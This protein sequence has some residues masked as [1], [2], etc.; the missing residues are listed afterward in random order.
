ME[1]LSENFYARDTVSVANDLL[2]KVLVHESPQGTTSGIIVETEAYLENDPA[3]HAYRGMT[4]RNA[5]MFGPPGKAYVYLIYGIH[6]CFNAVTR[7][8]GKGE[9][10]LV[11]SLCPLE[12][13]EL[14]R[15]RRGGKCRETRLSCGPGNLCKS[16]GINAG[17]DKI[18]LEDSPLHVLSDNINVALEDIGV[19]KRVG[20]NKGDNIFLRFYLKGYEKFVSGR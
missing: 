1:V 2:G 5:T 4:K 11:R 13:I 3:C 9:A 20:L 7:E 15:E 6:Y 14:M 8:E 16:M 12:G 18:S 19:S 10:V 17:H